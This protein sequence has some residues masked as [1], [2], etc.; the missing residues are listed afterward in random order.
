[1]IYRQRCYKIFDK[2][3]FKVDLIKVNWVRFYHDPNQNAPLEYFLQ[4]VEKLHDKH[5]LYINI[6]H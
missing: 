6:K 2:L 1:M 5:A 4:I 3:Q